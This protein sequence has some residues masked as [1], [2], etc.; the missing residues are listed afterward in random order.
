MAQ[1]CW[2]RF[3]VGLVAVMIAAVP[4]TTAQV[5][6]ALPTGLSTRLQNDWMSQAG[7]LE[8]PVWPT[9]GAAPLQNPP[10]FSWPAITGAARYELRL[11]DDQ[12]RIMQR[13]ARRNWL[14]WGESLAAGEYSWQVRSVLANA[15]LGPWSDPRPFQIGAS[16]IT[17]LPPDPADML[18][19]ARARAHPR[20]FAQ[21]ADRAALI[22]ATQ[23]ERARGW[24][25]LRASVRDASK[26]PLEADPTTQTGKAAINIQQTVQA[27]L[28]PQVRALQAACA[29]WLLSGDQADLD[30]A[31]RRALHLARWNPRGATGIESQPIAARAIA[32][33]LA[34]AFDWLHEMLTPTERAIIAHAAELRLQDLFE[35]VMGTERRLERWPYDSIGWVTLVHVAAASSLLIGH[36]DRAE[37]WFNDTAPLVA[38]RPTPWGTEDGGFANGVTYA[39][40]DIGESLLPFDVLRWATGLDMYTH[41][42]MRNYP[43]FFHAF[44]S[45]GAPFAAFGDGGEVRRSTEWAR[46]A[47]AVA[48]RMPTPAGDLA[49]DRWIGEDASELA[50]LLG[51]LRR[52]A[53]TSSERPLPLAA[54]FPSIGWAAMRC[55]SDSIGASVYFKS[56]AY[57]S[58]GHSHAD[59][60]AFLIHDNDR[61][62]AVNSGSYDWYGSQH[63][64][65]WTRRTIAHNAVTFDGGRGQGIGTREASG[66]LLG[67]DHS[68]FRDIVIGDATRA[69][70]GALKRA[71]R[72][73]IFVRPNL[74]IV[75]DVL[76][77]DVPR[78]WEWNL[79]S[80]DV[81]S[82]RDDG[83]FELRGEGRPRCGQ[84]SA[85]DKFSVT[86]SNHFPVAPQNS[87]AVSP[88]RLQV[89]SKTPSSSA[90][91]VA[92]IALDCE[93]L[94]GVRAERNGALEWTVTTSGIKFELRTAAPFVIADGPN[95]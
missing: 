39:M 85:S 7:F 72:A 94:P 5:L 47:K 23:V 19:S 40:W 11:L 89:A 50:L 9:A 17:F 52:V 14:A 73:L 62:I 26:Q 54:V 59:Q 77:S 63:W 46:H 69:Y 41:P 79:H 1:S 51:P 12:G 45:P 68:N 84:M 33:S 25:L 30:E 53:K 3:T 74:V 57:G 70:G 55:C 2:C 27:I 43:N 66:M 21:G 28:Y 37:Q 86:A 10:A 13:E 22:E 95:P 44:L 76:E 6:T 78:M 8:M 24:R 38:H 71:V 49:F 91:F 83:R 67:F 16:A 4:V 87:P 34:L 32:W 93:R 35:S 42:W 18:R 81:I 90:T 15:A 65:Q 75:F 36:V 31:R 88:W 61:G 92:I 64:Q 56:S 80:P 29:A 48:I 20:G 60:N 58:Y 82:G